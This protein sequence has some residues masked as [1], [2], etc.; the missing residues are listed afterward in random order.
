[1]ERSPAS[2]VA[3]VVVA[4][5]VVVVLVVLISSCGLRGLLTRLSPNN[6]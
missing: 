6:L 5:V 4:V 2:L 1:M 3:V